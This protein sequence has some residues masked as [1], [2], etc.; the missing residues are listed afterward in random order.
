L[1]IL[2]V[3]SYRQ[4]GFRH[5]DAAEL[6]GEGDWHGR[7]EMEQRVLAVPGFNSI[8]DGPDTAGRFCC[9]DRRSWVR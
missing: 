8:H 7:K 5:E 9:T 2:V 4:I 1:L 3:N 6:D